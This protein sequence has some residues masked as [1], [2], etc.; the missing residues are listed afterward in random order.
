MSRSLELSQPAQLARVERITEE[1][2]P[3]LLPAAP[4]RRQQRRNARQ[5][6]AH[7]PPVYVTQVTS[8]DNVP[9]D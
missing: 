6:R 8:E 1:R 5:Y 2:Q 4:L 3:E 9:G 7:A